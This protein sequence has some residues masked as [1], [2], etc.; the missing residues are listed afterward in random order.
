[1]VKDIIKAI[2]G[3][4]LSPVLLVRTAAGSDPADG[5]HRVSMAYRVDPYAEVPLKLASVSGR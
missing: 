2:E 1:M 4:A 5:F 3:K